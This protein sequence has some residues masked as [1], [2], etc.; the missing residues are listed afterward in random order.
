MTEWCLAHP[1]MTFILIGSSVFW[2]CLF[3]L[4]YIASALTSLFKIFCKHDQHK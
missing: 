4:A 2:F 1:W 3:G